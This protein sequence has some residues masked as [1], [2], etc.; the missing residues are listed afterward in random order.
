M[1][2]G[3]HRLPVKT[4]LRLNTV[5]QQMRVSMKASVDNAVLAQVSREIDVTL[6]KDLR[7][8]K[9]DK[10]APRVSLNTLLMAAVTR[11]L[12]G[13]PLLNA[14]LVD[15]QILIYDPINLGMAVAVP[16]GLM[17]VVIRDAHRLTLTDMAIAV[18]DCVARARHGQINPADLE[19]STF[20]VSNLGM[21]EIDGGFPR[22]R[23]PEGAMLLVGTA[24]PKPAVVNGRVVPRDIA[25]F[26]LSF[27]HRFIDGAAAAAFLKDLNELI[28]IPEMLLHQ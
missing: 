24:R 22:P 1:T 26:S 13:H 3:Q 25:W 18:E 28:Q 16:D 6:L 11:T 4:T 12:V 19:G 15:D 27:D 21:Y 17:V 14:E 9:F 10:S 23:P 5:R 20:T 2:E 8:K 7:R